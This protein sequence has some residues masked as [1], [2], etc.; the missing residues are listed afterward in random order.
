[1][2]PISIGWITAS[3]LLAIFLSQ[4]PLSSSGISTSFHHHNWVSKNSPSPFTQ[5]PIQ[6]CNP[7]SRM[8]G[9]ISATVHTL[10]LVFLQPWL[11]ILHATPSIL[12]CCLH[13]VQVLWLLAHLNRPGTSSRCFCCYLFLAMHL[14]DRELGRGR[15]WSGKCFIR[16]V[17]YWRLYQTSQG[18]KN[19]IMNSTRG[20]N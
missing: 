20:L 12:S 1:M 7:R 13:L 9:V 5:G 11:T 6:T 17:S 19:S 15:A 16:H 14:V 2:S 8:N 18:K 4:Y 3:H 10:R